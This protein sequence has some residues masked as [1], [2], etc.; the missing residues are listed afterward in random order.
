VSN[1]KKK[2]PSGTAST[3]R[4]PATTSPPRRGLLDGLLAPRTPGASPMPKFR[5]TLARG[6][7][8]ALSQ[9]WLVAAIPVTMLVV[10]VLLTTLGF[11][12]PFTAMGVT[13][14]IPPI[15][16]FADAQVAGKTFRAAIG[17]SG[18]GVA[19]P[20]L[21]GITSL[22]LFHAAVDALVTTMSVEKLRTGAVSAWA[23]RRAGRV[24]RTTATVGLISLGLLIAGN[25]IAAFLGGI[26]VIFGLIGSMVVGVYLFGFAP[27]IATD[28][29]R[30]VT[31]NLV[32]SVRAAR[33]PG[34]ANL[35]LAVGYVM[36]SLIVLIAPLP[37]STIGVTPPMSA[38]AAAIAINVV[39][40]IVQATLAYRYLA[41]APEIPEQPVARQ[42]PARRR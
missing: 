41:V 24:I 37:G 11:Q 8:T 22:L 30:R 5:S 6:I 27:T 9:P 42:A 12:G 21:I 40:V 28:E 1:K 14:A 15:T 25:V 29:E 36:V 3:Y 31:D 38:W 17:A 33:M 19:L 35:W 10:W 16:S 13:F 34:S 32:R 2:R 20:G 7:V 4:A 39:H 18:V 23:V 26:G